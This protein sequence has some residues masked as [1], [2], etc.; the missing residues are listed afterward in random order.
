MFSP[1]GKRVVAAYPD[2]C[3]RLFDVE[4]SAQVISWFLILFGKIGRCAKPVRF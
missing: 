4:T 2:D 1:D 3:V